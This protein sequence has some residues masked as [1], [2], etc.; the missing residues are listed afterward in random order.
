MRNG[1][2]P[3]WANTEPIRISTYSATYTPERKAI[4]L[5]GGGTRT[6]ILLSGPCFRIG[7]EAGRVATVEADRGDDGRRRAPKRSRKRR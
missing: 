3:Q 7:F 1:D 4:T 5:T 2:P 6:R